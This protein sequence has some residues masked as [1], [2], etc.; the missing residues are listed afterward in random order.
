MR[1]VP[2]LRV[3]QRAC[4]ITVGLA[5]LCSK[6]DGNAT[7]ATASNLYESNISAS[8]CPESKTRPLLLS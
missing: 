8:R 5:M 4:R 3:L 7:N 6:N 1:H 2:L